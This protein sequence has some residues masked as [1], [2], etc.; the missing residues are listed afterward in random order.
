MK[1]Q[2]SFISNCNYT[3]YQMFYKRFLEL[4]FEMG[5]CI[6]FEFISNVFFFYRFASISVMQQYA[7]LLENFDNNSTAVNDS[8]FTMMH[9]VAGDCNKPEVL[10]QMTI[11][12]IFT[13]LC[14]E[15]KFI[16]NVRKTFFSCFCFRKN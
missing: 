7:R 15:S 5:I 2:Y 4:Y 14:D 16:S 11:L 1:L 8:I 3:Y 10:M 13:D 12:K 6:W 9:H